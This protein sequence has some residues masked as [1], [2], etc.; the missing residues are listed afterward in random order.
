MKVFGFV[1]FNNTR[2]NMYSER[3]VLISSCKHDILVPD[4]FEVRSGR[5]G[6]SREWKVEGNINNDQSLV[7]C[8]RNTKSRGIGK[9]GCSGGP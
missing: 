9:H 7:T 5:T 2:L 4:A 6:K 1:L 3:C 8:I